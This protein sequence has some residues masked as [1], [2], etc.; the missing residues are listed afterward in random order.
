M[1][2]IENWSVIQKYI[3]PYKSPEQLQGAS[4]CGNVYGHP[5]WEDGHHIT[6]SSIIH[7]EGR[8]VFTRNS[9]YILGS[10][11]SDYREWYENNHN[12]PFNE[13]DHFNVG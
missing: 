6:T 11:S 12:K 3:D 8:N 13:D 2:K 10:A 1:Y 4:I 7:V 5:K 9:K